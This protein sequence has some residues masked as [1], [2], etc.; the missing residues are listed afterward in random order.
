M[1]FG[2]PTL[3]CAI[4]PSKTLEKI[5]IKQA[6]WIFHFSAIY[7]VVQVNNLKCICSSTEL[8]CGIIHTPE[9]Q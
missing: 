9:H 1:I 4:F 8:K 2:S 3:K 7:T 6:G 5:K